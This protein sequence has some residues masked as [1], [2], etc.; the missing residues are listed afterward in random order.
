MSKMSSKKSSQE[1]RKKPRAPRA[2]SPT[3]SHPGAKRAKSL[4]SQ[5]APVSKKK[6]ASAASHGRGRRQEPAQVTAHPHSR[7]EPRSDLRTSQEDSCHHCEKNLQNEERALF[8]EEEVGRI[9]CTEECITQFFSAEIDRLEKEY[10][11]HLAS[12]DLTDKEREKLAHLRWMTLEEPDEVW[13]QKT[14]AGDFRYTLVSEFQ[15]DG[16]KPVWYV[17]ICLFL[18]GE[19]SFLYLAFPTKNPAMV[20]HYRRGE[21]VVWVRPD[22]KTRDEQRAAQAEGQE[23]Q[24]SAVIDGLADGWTEEET[25]RAQTVQE[26]RPDDIPAE[27]F[28]LYE[29]QIEQALD[30][31]DEV[32][33]FET[34]D[35]AEPV[36]LFHFIKFYP[37]D[38]ENELFDEDPGLWFVIVAREL[39]NEEQIEILDAFPT[40][41]PSL[42]DRYRK[43]SQDVGE[44]ETQAV[45][46]LVH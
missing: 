17:C 36:R 6:T 38:E 27:D 25:M 3:A 12:G 16:K 10:Y 15:P 14:L 18:R 19:P 23:P 44:S 26:R 13:R 40:R 2:S 11:K 30:A 9:F 34:S 1:R 8:V 21:R 20:N 46:R 24:V 22:K 31:P 28:Q 45:S 4:S 43:G 5:K 35:E 29:R 32:W 42:V 39:E 33:S 41:D 37:V 7:Q